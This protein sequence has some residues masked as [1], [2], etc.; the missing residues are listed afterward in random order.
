MVKI[1]KRSE[2]KMERYIRDMANAE[3]YSE[4]Q[5]KRNVWRRI[6]KN[7]NKGIPLSIPFYRIILYSITFLLLLTGTMG[8]FN[9]SQDR[10]NQPSDTIISE[11]QDNNT[12]NS[13][14]KNQEME[15]ETT[16]VIEA[17]NISINM[18][19]E[20]SDFPDDFSF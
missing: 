6:E 8:I 5:L 9:N 12:V 18:L 1:E 13:Q 20:D 17:I 3:L 10:Y 14:V 7:I 15:N 19:E 4:H 16:S 11:E 2:E